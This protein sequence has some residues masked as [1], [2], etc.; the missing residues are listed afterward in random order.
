[1]AN[2]MDESDE[3]ADADAL[4]KEAFEKLKSVEEVD[5]EALP[6]QFGAFLREWERD[7]MEIEE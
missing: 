1:M 6:E 5:P 2:I 7:L 4:Y 3:A